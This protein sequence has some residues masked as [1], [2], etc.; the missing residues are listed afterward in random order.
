MRR[1]VD[2]YEKYENSIILEYNIPLSAA[3]ALARWEGETFL[4][5][6]FGATKPLQQLIP[7]SIVESLVHIVV[8]SA[9]L[10]NFDFKLGIQAEITVGPPP[11][12]RNTN[13]LSVLR[14]IRVFSAKIFVTW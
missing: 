14:N 11:A 12:N 4:R 13:K 9:G 10:H 7:S 8:E 5:I 1:V 3:K 6:A 2:A